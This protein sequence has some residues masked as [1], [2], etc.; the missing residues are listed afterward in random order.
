MAGLDLGGVAGL[1][2]FLLLVDGLALDCG[3]LG[4]EPRGEELGFVHLALEI[5]NYAGGC[6]VLWL[7]H[8]CLTC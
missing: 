5:A 1:L 8:G 4:L 7:V 3:G 2:A 6:D